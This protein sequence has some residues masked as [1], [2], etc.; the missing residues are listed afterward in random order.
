MVSLSLSRRGRAEPFKCLFVSQRVASRQRLRPAA[1][2]RASLL[3]LGEA[4][5][6]L[7]GP[8]RALLVLQL[9]DLDAQRQHF[10]Y[11]NLTHAKNLAL[12]SGS[13]LPSLPVAVKRTSTGRVLFESSWSARS[14]RWTLHVPRRFGSEPL[15]MMSKMSCAS[16]LFTG[17]SVNVWLKSIPSFFALARFGRPDLDTCAGGP[18]TLV[19]SRLVDL[20]DTTTLTFLA[21]DTATPSIMMSLSEMQPR[22]RPW[23]VSPTPVF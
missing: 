5:G 6:R 15:S 10:E 11:W 7:L 23:I 18:G 3:K 9:V 21:A 14:R 12:G 1:Q 20:R 2:A 8:Q 19:S 22:G 16:W 4:Q 17:A 13:N